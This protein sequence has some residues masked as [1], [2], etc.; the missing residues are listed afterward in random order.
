MAIIIYGDCNGGKYLSFWDQNRHT[1]W[2][3]VNFFLTCIY[4]VNL[5]CRAI[6][7][8]RTSLLQCGQCTLS[9]LASVSGSGRD[10]EE[11]CLEGPGEAGCSHRAVRAAIQICSR[12]P[13]CHCS[14]IRSRDWVNPST[15]GVMDRVFRRLAGL[16]RGNSRGRSQR[17][18]PRSSPASPRKNPS[19]LTLLLGFTFYLK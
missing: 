19:T 16:L 13:G 4:L 3:Q 2:Y 9:L 7:E 18:I 1:A 14:R 10:R 15:K 17:D 5:R 8:A 11:A 12:H 6:E